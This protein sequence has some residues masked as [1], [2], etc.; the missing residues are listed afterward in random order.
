M[1]LNQL[2]LLSTFKKNVGDF[3]LKSGM[4]FLKITE[5]LEYWV[6]VSAWQEPDEFDSGADSL[7]EG[8]QGR[9]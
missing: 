8:G 9:N 3:T 2:D 7:E 6:C 5:H 1:F 4:L